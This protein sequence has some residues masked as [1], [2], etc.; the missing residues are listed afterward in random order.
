MFR[1]LI[2]LALL[3]CSP[4]AIATEIG[5]SK[6][7][8]IGVSAGTLSGGLSAKIYR[9]NGMAIQGTLGSY[10]AY[11][12]N[13]LLLT[14]DIITE[15]TTLFQ[16]EAGRLLVTAGAGGSALMVSFAGTSGLAL[17]VNGVAGLAWH[18]SDIP[19]EMTLEWRPTIVLGD[20]FFSGIYI[21][22]NA[23]AI[24]YFF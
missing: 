14:T 13:S 15:V 3:L 21:N 20:Q 9:D 5:T 2:G 17:G 23:L 12:A 11:W 10:T 24:R 4:Q 19:L 6:T 1:L 7:T 16:E 8:G 18:F 22:G